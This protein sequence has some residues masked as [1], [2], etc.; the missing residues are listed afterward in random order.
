MKAAVLT[1]PGHI[2][3]VDRQEPSCGPGEVLVRVTGVGICGSD[4]TVFGGGRPVPEMPWVMGHEGIGV[5]SAIGPDVSD[6]HVG[7]RVVIEPNYPCF[8]CPAC[9]RGETCGCRNKVMI[10]MNTPGLLAEFVVIP[11]RFA[12]PTPS[13]LTDGQMVCLE[14]LAVATAAL[15]RAGG[16]RPSQRSVVVG[17]GSTGLIFC[18]TLLANGVRPDVIEPHAGRAELAVSLGAR[19]FQEGVDGPYDRVYETSGVAS[20]VEQALGLARDGGTVTLTGLGT[21]PVTTTSAAIV[22]HRLT[23][24]GSLV[25]DHPRDFAA[26]LA[27]PLPALDRIIRAEF[28]LER[29]QEAFENARE[30]PGKSWISMEPE[31]QG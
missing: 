16:V 18:A 26:T 6:R 21:T 1:G 24:I 17:A 7:Q 31:V 4:L 5:I 28:P 13:G 2:D 10:G 27:A 23:I 20:A 25:Y 15:R 12:W 29:A 30:V 9:S 22:R 3:L 11:A 19:I 14:P 8:D